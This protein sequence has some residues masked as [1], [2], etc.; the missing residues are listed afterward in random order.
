R[1]AR[2]LI[3]RKNDCVINEDWRSAEPVKHIEWPKRQLPTF[4]AVSV[5]R[6]HSELLEE[7]VDVFAVGDRAWRRR[8]VYVLKSSRARARNFSLPD[9][10]AGLSI[11]ANDKQL[12][13][14]F[15]ATV[16]GQENSVARKHRGGMA[17]RKR[18]F[19]DDV[20][21]GPELQRQSGCD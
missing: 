18:C 14:F 20:F 13:V 4:L 1:S 15:F 16:S 10:L 11:E 2:I 19:P 6:N 17:R 21:V 5:V 12:G 7:D 8:T 3:H 9:L